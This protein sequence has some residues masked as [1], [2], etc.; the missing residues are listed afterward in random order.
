MKLPDDNIRLQHITDFA[1]RAISFVNDVTRE[2]FNKNEVLQYACV[3]L[4][5]IIGEAANGLTDQ[6]RDQYPSIPWLKMINMRNRLI[7]GYIDVDMEIVW[8]TL[9]NDLPP[10][11]D[12]LSRI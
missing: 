12:Q 4:L 11:V 10:L 7:H 6:T 9:K 1:G 2:E 3:H 5:E 8:R